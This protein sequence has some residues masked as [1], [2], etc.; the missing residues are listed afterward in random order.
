MFPLLIEP[1]ETKKQ[2]HQKAQEHPSRTGVHN[3]D[4]FPREASQ[5]KQPSRNEGRV[6]RND[7]PPRFQRDS[8]FPKPSTAES[9]PL[10]PSQ[11]QRWNDSEKRGRGGVEQRRDERRDAKGGHV[12]ATSAGNQ[13][14]KG[15]QGQSVNFSQGSKRDRGLRELDH[16]GGADKKNQ[17]N[18]PL[19]AKPLESVGMDRPEPHSKRKGRPDRPNSTHFDRD[20]TGNW[21][22]VHVP[23][24]KDS[25]VTHDG[26]QTYFVKGGGNPNTLLQ[27]GD[28]EPRRTGPIKPQTSGPPHKN[29]S[30][31]NSAPK[32]RSGPIKGHRGSEMGYQAESG[33]HGNWKS[34]DQCLALYWEDNKVS[35]EVRTRSV[36]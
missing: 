7:R 29:N 8:D 13:R 33:N 3:P 17:A 11:P 6:Q 20:T 19:G 24:M 26:G 35:G 28:P 1:L 15:Q 34:G 2:P 4:H 12:N 31:Y 22:S 36:S 23:G 5:N 18:G 25:A 30:F 21:N 14:S 27:N 32:K 10:I 16:A 9:S